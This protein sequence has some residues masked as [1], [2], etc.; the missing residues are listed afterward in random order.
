MAAAPTILEMA[1]GDRGLPIDLIVLCSHGETGFKRWAVGSVAQKVA[2]HSPVPVLILREGNREHA[3][4]YTDTLRPLRALV[5][6]DGSPLAEAA[7]VPAAQ[8]VAALAARAQGALRLAQIV[9]LPTIHDQHDDKQ[10]DIDEREHILHEATTYLSAVADSLCS[11]LAGELG[12]KATWSIAVNDDVADAL[13]RMAEL[14]EETG[15]YQVEGCDL[16]AIATHGR[17]GLQRWT[18]G[19]VTERVLDGTKLPLLIVRPQE[20][21]A[22]ATSEPRSDRIDKSHATSDK[23]TMAPIQE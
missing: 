18:M 14:G 4:L 22:S 9:K 12:L 8:L 15:T 13:I 10:S 1:G 19:S 20:Q 23:A 2:R 7:L 6:L 21:H 17:G 11:G 5:A 16:I 3:K